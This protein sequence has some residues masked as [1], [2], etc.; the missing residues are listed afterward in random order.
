MVQIY[1]L[2]SEIKDTKVRYTLQLSHNYVHYRLLGL[3][4]FLIIRCRL[5]E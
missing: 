4:N 3:Y 1:L 5:V 2:C